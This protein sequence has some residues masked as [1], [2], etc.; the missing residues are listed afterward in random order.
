MQEVFAVWKT[1]FLE[2]SPKNKFPL[3]VLNE[4]SLA[5]ANFLLD[6]LKIY[7]QKSSNAGK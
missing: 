4:I 1:K 5:Q 3:Y 2:H 7:L 6:Q